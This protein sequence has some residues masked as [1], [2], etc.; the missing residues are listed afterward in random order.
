MI[1]GDRIR[2][3]AMERADLPHFQRWLND[4]EVRMGIMLYLP[5]SQIGEDRWFDQMIERPGEEHPLAI[6][7]GDGE[8]WTLI[9]NCGLFGF[10]WRVRSAELGI[11]IGDKTQWDQGFGTEATNLIVGFGVRTLNL[12]RIFLRVFAN[13]PRAFRAYEKAGFVQEGRLRQASYH[14]G[15][16]VDVLM[17]GILRSEWETS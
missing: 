2:L 13:N 6:E 10:D 11:L 8:A 4:P 9:G 14:D 7:V 3:R 1:Y 12:R 16:Y 5:V 17:M 15:D